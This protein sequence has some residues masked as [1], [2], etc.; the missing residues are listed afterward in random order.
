MKTSQETEKSLRKFLEP[1]HKLEAIF[2][3]SSLEFG[4]YC[5]D[6]SW[7]HC[8]STPQR[9]E[10]NGMGERAVRRIKEGTSA[11]LLQS[12]LDEKWWLHG[13]LLL[14]VKTSCQM[15]KHP[16]TGDSEN[17]VKA[18]LFRWVP[19]LNIILFLRRTSQG[20]TNLVR[21]FHLEYSSD[22]HCSRE[23]FGKEILRLQT[24]RTW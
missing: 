3:D 19:W 11:V 20:S 21:K 22:V 24:V 8:T 5:E 1:S 16:M 18:R 15:G 4:K 7:N 2:T 14:P 9:S 10:T 17:H 6:L 13:M 12:G 23:E